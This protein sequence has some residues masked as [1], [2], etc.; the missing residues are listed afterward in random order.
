MRESPVLLPSVISQRVVLRV[1]AGDLE[2]VRLPESITVDCPCGKF[3]LSVE[4]DG[5]WVTLTR[6]LSLTQAS[7]S[8]DMW[9]ELRGVLL[10]NGSDRGRTLVFR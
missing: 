6:E 10:A 3:T 8:P 9:M 2:I 4:E 1:K 5:D 7:I